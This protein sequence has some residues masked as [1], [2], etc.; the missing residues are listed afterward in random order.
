[1]GRLTKQQIEEQARKRHSGGY[2]GFDADGNR[3]VTKW[4][5]AA[6]DPRGKPIVDELRTCPPL[7]R[8]LELIAELEQM[9]LI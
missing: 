1:M 9:R 3:V 2:D 5:R 7:D 4:D 8:T 6:E